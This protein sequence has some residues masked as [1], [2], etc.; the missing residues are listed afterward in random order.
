MNTQNRLCSNQKGFS[1]IELMV[2]ATLGLMILAGAM[3]MFV[4]N[5]RVYNEQDELGRL[6]ENARFAIDML[7]RDIRM[8]GYTGCADEVALVCNHVAGNTSPATGKADCPKTPDDASLYAFIAVEGSEAAQIWRPSSST[9]EQ[10]NMNAG[11]DALTIRYLGPTDIQVVE[12]VNKGN[13]NLFITQNSNLN[14][15]DIIAV[16]DCSSAD[17]IV[18]TSL[19]FASGATPCTPSTSCKSTLKH[20]TGSSTDPEN[21]FQGFSK[22]YSLDSEIFRYVTNRYYIGNDN[23]NPVLF[24]KEGSG[25]AVAMIDG[26]ENMQLLYGVDTAG[27]DSIADSYLQAGAAGLVTKADWERVVSVRVAL[28]IRTVAE[29]GVETNTATYDLLGNTINPVDDRRRRRVFTT[30]VQIRNRSN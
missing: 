2:A 14:A 3:A 7:V 6:Q 1:I 18:T 30:T 5:K 4:N 17:I 26:V 16:S 21:A 22:D 28:L 23:G 11:S 8:A 10:G 25:P 20:N 24:R 9:E 27:N 15:G 13:A 29:Y 19:N 12:D